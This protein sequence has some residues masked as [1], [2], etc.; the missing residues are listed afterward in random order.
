V[1]SFSSLNFLRNLFASINL[2]P[3]IQDGCQVD[4]LDFSLSSIHAHS[5]GIPHVTSSLCFLPRMSQPL[6]WI[7]KRGGSYGTVS[8]VSLR[9]GDLLYSRLIGWYNP[10]SLVLFQLR[11]VFRCSWHMYTWTTPSIFLKKIGGLCWINPILK[12]SDNFRFSNRASLAKPEGQ[13]WWVSWPLHVESGSQFPK[14]S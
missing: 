3:K 4:I 10:F 11:V 13:H 2:P 12:T 9:M 6:V 8:P 7:P 14:T 5:R 1:R